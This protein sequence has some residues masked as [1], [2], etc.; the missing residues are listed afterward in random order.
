MGARFAA[1]PDLSEVIGSQLRESQFLPFIAY[2][3]RFL[4]SQMLL[5]AI[6]LDDGAAVLWQAPD[7]GSVVVPDFS[8]E[9]AENG[10]VYIRSHVGNRYVTAEALDS[11]V[12]KLTKDSPGAK[13]KLSRADHS[14]FERDLFVISNQAYPTKVLQPS[15]RISESAVVLGDSGQATT[16]RPKLRNA[17]SVTI[18]VG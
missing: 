9:D 14:E 2:R 10:F 13:W 8:F 4:E 1:A 7:D 17:W 16:I 5:H 3:L 18:P 15:D 6:E 12:T 11:V